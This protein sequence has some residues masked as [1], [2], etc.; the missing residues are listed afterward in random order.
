MCLPEFEE[1]VQ[2]HDFPLPEPEIVDEEFEEECKLQ[3][4]VNKIIY[5]YSII[6]LHSIWSENKSVLQCY[7]M[8]KS[9]M[10]KIDEMMKNQDVDKE[11]EIEILIQNYK[12]DCQTFD[13]KSIYESTISKRLNDHDKTVEN[14]EEESDTWKERVTLLNQEIVRTKSK[15]KNLG[16]TLDRAIIKD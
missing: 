9:Y 12:I 15:I 14:I 6:E 4:L 11:K 8:N 5:Q 3:F 13:W 16:K 1:K 2:D 7:K 10:K